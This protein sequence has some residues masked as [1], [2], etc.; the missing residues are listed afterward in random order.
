MSVKSQQVVF[1]GRMLFSEPV[2]Y[3]NKI[4]KNKSPFILGN[5]KNFY[6]DIAQDFMEVWAKGKN[7]TTK[8]TIKSTDLYI[9]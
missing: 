9:M 1:L 3:Y 7:S 6:W 5:D 8:P 4:Y 2:L